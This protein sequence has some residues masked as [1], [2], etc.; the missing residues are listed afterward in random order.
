MNSIEFDKEKANILK[1]LLE[2]TFSNSL[3]YLEKR[4]EDHFN[5][6][7][8]TGKQFHNFEQNIRSLILLSKENIMKKNLENKE[9]KILTNNSLNTSALLT[10]NNS[11][12][13]SN[14]KN[15]TKKM[16]RSRTAASIHKKES[17]NQTNQHL[18]NNNNINNNN[19]THNK[20]H[21]TNRNNITFSIPS[22]NSLNTS[23]RSSVNKQNTSLISSKKQIGKN[24]LENN[25]S[26]KKVDLRSKSSH[27]RTNET[28]DKEIENFTS[29]KKKKIKTV[30]TET[31]SPKILNKSA[32]EP[33]DFKFEI[34]NIQE[35]IKH[36]EDTLNNTEKVIILQKK[37]KSP[38]RER[39]IKFDFEFK[40]IKLEADLNFFFEENNKMI[41]DNII[42]FC[43]IEEAMNLLSFNKK[44]CKEERIKYINNL[45]KNFGEKQIEQKINEIENKNEEAL[46]NPLPEFQLSKYSLKIIEELN[47]EVFLNIFYYDELPNKYKDILIVY[48]LFIQLIKNENLLQ[49]TNDKE[50]WREISNYFI[51]EGKNKLGDFILNLS[52]NFS[53]D[54]NNINKM[55][56]LIHKNKAKIS[57]TYYSKI[58]GTTA[59]IVFILKDALEYSG[60]LINEKK[61]PVKRIYDN[62]IKE[63]EKINKLNDILKNAQNL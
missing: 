60:I 43:E 56:N 55:R 8:M 58:C 32:R 15:E 50:F 29:L 38:E 23:L 49:I 42:P 21:H 31:E 27:S 57:R 34:S 6:L 26:N 28:S 45:I 62:L 61:T 53:F 3:K 13:K 22:N 17:Q 18:N 1:N 2:K 36:V 5:S 24:I 54:D 30:K 41:L 16:I 4:T 37:T 48:K 63:K 44:F 14:N 19:I 39:K 47:Q 9:N 35:Q 10:L 25:K 52:K 46:N 7:T 20:T 40:K 51:T 33:F 59:S 11:N 12:N